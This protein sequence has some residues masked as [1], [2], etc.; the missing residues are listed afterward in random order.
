MTLGLKYKPVT[1]IYG[2][3]RHHLISDAHA[4]VPD[5]YS[6]CTHQFLTRTLR[7]SISSYAHDQHV[8]KGPFQIR[9]FYAYAEHTRKKLMRM[10]RVRI[11]STLSEKL[12]QDPN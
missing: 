11:S 6:Q 5:T 12:D 1:L 2:R 3:A 9:N 4:L 7:A 10:L 8:L